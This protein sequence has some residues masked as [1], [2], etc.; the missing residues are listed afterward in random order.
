VAFAN[1]KGI[2][3]RGIRKRAERTLEKLQEPLRKF[4]EPDEVVL[5]LARG[6][7]MPGGVEQLFLGWH[8][9]YLGPAMLVLTNRRLLHLFVARDGKW[10]R[11]LRCARWGDLE[12]AKVKG[13]LSP[14]LHIKYRDGKKEVFWR[15]RGD[16]ARTVRLL[17]ATLLPTAAGETS[18][19][20]AM[21]N[22]C[23][24]CRAPLTSGIYECPH[25]RLGFKDEKTAL[26]RSMLIPGGGFFYIGHSGL[27]ILHALVESL[28]ILDIA[29]WLLVALGIAHP[30]PRPGGAPAD[31]AS[32]VVTV[33]IVAG[34]LAVEK[35][36]MARVTRDQVRTYIPAGG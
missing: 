3:K 6:Q 20:L 16:D 15:M 24:E 4:L 5:Y 27:G 36:V 18:P 13:W 35:W 10:R 29:Y 28:L 2:E 12:E 22:L 7:T 1:R 23:P 14:K 26:W 33:A 21:T 34:L 19:A 9:Y 11:S 17:L 30:E 31:R 8:A 25:C 32:A